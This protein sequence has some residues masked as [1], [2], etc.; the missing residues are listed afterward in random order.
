MKRIAAIVLVGM[1]VGV[2]LMLRPDVPRDGEDAPSS[3]RGEVPGPALLRVPLPDPGGQ[4]AVARPHEAG[5]PRPA[6]LERSS[7]GGEA[8]CA[9]ADTEPALL[10]WALERTGA[11]PPGPEVPAGPVEGLVQDEEG[12]ALSGAMVLAVPAEGPALELHTDARG[13]YRAVLPGGPLVLVALRDGLLPA[14]R[15]EEH[16]AGVPLP[17]LTLRLPRTLAGRV[18]DESGPVAGAEVSLAKGRCQP[19]PVYTDASGR[20]RF[21]ELGTGSYVLTAREGGRIA[22]LDVSADS[23]SDTSN[24]LVTLAAPP[25]LT[26]SVVDNDE[27]PVPGAEVFLEEAPTSVRTVADTQGRFTL[28]VPPGL[29][30]VGA[31]APGFL[32]GSVG[33]EVLPG[34]REEVRLFL[35]RP[36]RIAGVVLGPEGPMAGARITT[37][38]RLGTH[39]PGRRVDDGTRSGPDG[40]FELERPEGSWWVEAWAPGYERA[41]VPLGSEPGSLRLRLVPKRA[42][43]LRGRVVDGAGR[44]VPNA[45]VKVVLTEGEADA[46]WATTDDTGSFVV[47]VPPGS[48]YTLQAEA[49]LAS[50][51]GRRVETG[52]R[53]LWSPL[54]PGGVTLT[55][56]GGPGRLSGVVRTREGLP[57]ADAFVGARASSTEGMGPTVEPGTARG[58]KEERYLHHLGLQVVE[59]ATPFMTR[60]GAD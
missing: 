22:R 23:S 29:V 35:P 58:W 52:E 24:L 26:G 13:V 20:F 19:P 1:A 15:D 46:V 4:Q 5:T 44:G 8:P 7:P 37:F 33:V 30:R 11:H 18:E 40:R 51:T 17:P 14:V 38:R 54:P 60:S 12:R 55:L 47:D 21:D 59:Y 25:V 10:A 50:P 49:W 16:L 9:C 45:S 6:C 56:R 27:R 34:G 2:L 39:M 32:P 36:L 57:V 43:E 41:S 31:R 53:H 48:A 28:G 42:V 3:T